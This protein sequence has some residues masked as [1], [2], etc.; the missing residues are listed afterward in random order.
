MLLL[1][2]WLRHPRA[3]HGKRGVQHR[4]TTALLQCSSSMPQVQCTT[5]VHNRTSTPSL[6]RNAASQTTQTPHT[7]HV[8]EHT[9][10]VPL[11]A[12]KFSISPDVFEM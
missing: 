8:G 2:P 7:P 1:L 6:V 4:S 11:T 10:E 12:T 5:A 9:R 3:H